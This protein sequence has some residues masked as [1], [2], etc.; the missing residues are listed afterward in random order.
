MT[1]RNWLTNLGALA[2]MPAAAAP[3]PGLPRK[4]ILGTMMQAFWG[5]HPGVAARVDELAAAVEKMAAQSQQ[6]YG[7]HPD[8][9]ILP[10]TSISGE[11][12]GDAYARA[13][14]YEGVVGRT[15]EKLAKAHQTYIIVAT[16]L[17]EAGGSKQCSNA[18]VLVDRK[19]SVE[20]IYR[21]VHL[22]P[23]AGG[24]FEGGTTPGREFPVFTCD[25]GKL[26]IQICYDME[27]D[28]G[29]RE[30]QRKGAEI[31]AWPT[32]SPQRAHPC[33]RAME[34]PAYIVSSTW[35]SNA[36]VFEPTGKIVA[37]IQKP[38]EHVLVQEI[39]LSYMILPWSGKLRNGKAL[40]D[41]F[42]DRAGFR[43]YEDEDLG[44][45]WS[46]NPKM[47]I[48]EMARG[49]GL[50]TAEAELARVRKLYQEAGIVGY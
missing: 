23:S 49:M 42:G 41:K 7:R 31:V 48:A 9:L 37:G 35:R 32:Q 30:L 10:E 15:F 4:V 29:W 21:K 20:G 33:A 11:A 39:D 6:K 16:Y 28:N 8:L 36:S 26:G 3:S 22:V 50:I 12:D 45:F 47:G 40:R 18:A 19:G 44:M 24:G 25:F 34:L 46:N 1:R 27:F 17:R 13:V 14:S 5:K 38:E 43:Y 2:A